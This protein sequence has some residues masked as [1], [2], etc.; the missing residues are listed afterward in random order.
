MHKTSAV[1]QFRMFNIHGWLARQNN[2][3]VHF[4]NYSTYGTQD[5]QVLIISSTSGWRRYCR[6]LI[7]RGSRFPEILRN[8]NHPQNYFSGNCHLFQYFKEEGWKLSTNQPTWSTRAV[9][10]QVPLSSIITANTKIAAIS[11][12]HKHRR[13]NRGGRGARAPQKL[14]SL[15]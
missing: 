4:P 10:K 12:W 9:S 6:G 13:W 2:I 1:D 15:T 5:S 11:C 8:C 7:Y 14:K 3:Q